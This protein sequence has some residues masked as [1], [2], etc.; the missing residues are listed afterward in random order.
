MATR[1]VFHS[2]PKYPYCRRIDI[3]FEYFPGFALSQTQRSINSLHTAYRQHDGC[4]NH[5]VLE[6]SS[7]SPALLGVKLSAFNLQ[8]ALANGET[9]PVEAVFQSSKC[10][11]NG[12]QYLDI[13][14]MTGRE[15]K[16]DV[17]IRQS[18]SLTG[19]RLEEKDYPLEPQTLFYNWVYI[20]ALL[21]NRDLAEQL[22]AYDAFTDIAFSPNKSIN[23]QAEA[24]A[25][26]VGLCRGGMLHEAASSIETFLN[27][28]Y[29]FQNTSKNVMNATQLSMF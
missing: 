16:R 3:D 29:K 15:A 23:C 14:S 12:K 11:E 17:R 19:F 10:F 18:G 4:S 27:V 2:L 6:I 21:Q 1:L 8:F 25:I 28:V 7:K 24:A 20:N 26:F 22:V 9:H 5:K 13:M